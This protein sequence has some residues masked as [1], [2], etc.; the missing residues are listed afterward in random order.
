VT[1]GQTSWPEHQHDGVGH[2]HP[3]YHLTH[4]FIE[5]VGGFEHLGYQHRHEH[6]HAADERHLQLTPEEDIGSDVEVVAQGKVLVDHLDPG[7]T[8]IERAAQVDSGTVE[9]R[10]DPVDLGEV[11]NPPAL[12]GN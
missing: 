6:T 9:L 5:R 4:N 10:R 3:H 1:T 8:G 7:A 12:G 11:A 2:E